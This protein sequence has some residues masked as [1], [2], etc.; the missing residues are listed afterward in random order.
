MTMVARQDEPDAADPVLAGRLAA[1]RPYLDGEVALTAVAAEHGIALRTARRWVARLRASGPAGLGRKRRSDTGRRRITPD[2]V[3]LV[4]GLALTRPRLSITTIHRRAREVA[5]IRG[6][7]GASYASV[8][9]IVTGLDPALVTLALDGDTAFRDRYEIIHRHRAERPNAT[10]QADHTQLDILIRDADGAEV[11]PWLTTVLDDHSRAIAGY[12]VFLGAPSALNTSLALRQA[13]WPKP[14]VDWPVCGI[15]D[16][17]HVDHGSDFTS[18]HLDQAA[19]DLRIRLVYSIVA[20]PQGRGKIERLFGTLNT[21]LLPELPGH[22]QNGKPSSTPCLSLTELDAA[23]GAFIVGNYNIR[24]HGE[25]GVAPVAAWRGTGWL[26]RLPDSLDALD[27]LLIMVAKPRVVRRDGIRF[28]GLRYFDPT[29]AAYVGEAVTVRYDPR[30]LGE[31]RVFHRNGFLCRAVSPERAGS[32]ITLKDV[33]A[34]RL[35]H[36][37]R[38]RG[39]IRGKRA[40]VRDLLPP[41]PVPAAAPATPPLRQPIAPRHPRLRT[42]AEDE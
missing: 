14:Q 40:C 25:I 12:M 17:L 32:R 13:I 36:R 11:R 6:W 35:A 41:A 16:V 7:S 37:R 4:E 21:E 29:L 38:L 33:Q 34:A 3:V 28:E 42:Y 24:V 1:L 9:A 20:R 15:P 26:P 39:I 5:R 10:W 22:L 31:I 27:G 2:L 18:R 19:S 30:D 8:H 23:I